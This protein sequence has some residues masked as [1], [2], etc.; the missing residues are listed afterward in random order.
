M[1]NISEMLEKARL[2]EKEY[3]LKAN[4]YRPDFHVTGGIGWI[5]DPNGF[6]VFNGEY[7]LFH[8][9]HPYSTEWG[10]MHW[11]HLKTSD[12]VKWERLP[13]ALAPDATFDKDGCY[14]GN[15]IELSDGR[16]LI[17]YTGVVKTLRED[18]NFDEV[19]HQCVAIGDGINYEKIDSNPV[20]SVN[21]IPKGASVCDFRDPKIWKEG[22]DYYALIANRAADGFGS[23]LMYTSKDGI[24]WN[25]VKVFAECKGRYGTMWE[26]PDFFS[27]DKRHILIISP[28]EMEA[29]GYEFHA[30]QGVIA[31]C[32]DYDKVNHDFEAEWVQ[33]V[34][35][36]TD[37]YAPETLVAPDGRRILIGWMR[38]WATTNVRPDNSPIFG[39]MTLPRELSLRA[40]RL[41]SNPVRELENYR[42][43]PVIYENVNVDKAVFFAGVSGRVIDMTVNV[44][45]GDYSFFKIKLAKEEGHC[46]SIVYRPMEDTVTIDRTLA[47]KRID[48][49]QNR[50]FNVS[51]QNGA[52]KFRIVMDKDSIELF[53]NDGERVATFLVYND[54]SAEGIEFESDK[55]T[56]V[57]IEKY[58]IKV[59]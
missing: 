27:L 17:L 10:P 1:S 7:H 33:A 24:S 29:E 56:K 9:Y 31:M 57:S 40:G 12:F 49:V 51:N 30:G 39:A 34:D 20:I 59:N 58:D 42:E 48:T 52:I 38:N 26:C 4:P 2:Y 15:A 32:G 23:L 16:H 36:G 44:C 28:M 6:S 37:F 55:T 25:F 3:E 46:A 14:S 47:S 19:Q 18:G 21:D 41:V 50:T 45:E 22:E 8:Q 5:N 13:V 35:Y 43:N 53:V 54:I 11:G